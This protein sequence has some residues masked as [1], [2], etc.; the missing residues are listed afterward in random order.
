MD[1]TKEQTD[2]L[3]NYLKAQ[4]AFDAH[5]AA[6]KVGYSAK[7]CDAVKSTINELK[8]YFAADEVDFLTSGADRP[9]LIKHFL[10]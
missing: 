5:V 7:M 3:A 10:G 8:K 2:A 9:E 4:V 1:L 6:A